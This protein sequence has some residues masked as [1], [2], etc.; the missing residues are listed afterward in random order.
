MDPS[1][2]YERVQEK[3]ENSKKGEKDR[4]RAVLERCLL[5]PTGTFQLNCKLKRI[6]YSSASGTTGT[7]RESKGHGETGGEEEDA[8]DADAIAPRQELSLPFPAREKKFF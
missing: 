7:S 2:K 3:P 4:E 8:R 1:E 6:F 5:S